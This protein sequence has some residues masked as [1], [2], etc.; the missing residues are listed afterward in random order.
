MICLIE[1]VARIEHVVAAHAA[2]LLAD[3]VGID[4]D[5]QA[6]AARAHVADRERHLAG[7][8]LLDRKIGLVRK[9]RNEV[10]I[11]SVEALRTELGGTVHRRSRAAAG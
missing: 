7:Q 11:E 2:R 9:R 5:R 6:H 8:G 4:K 1:V 3:Q 10:G